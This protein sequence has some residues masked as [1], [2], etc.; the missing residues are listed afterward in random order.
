MSSKLIP[1]I[2]VVAGLIYSPARDKIFIA[3]RPQGVHQGGLWEFPGGKVDRNEAA[4]DALCRELR[5]ELA[6]SVISASPLFRED[7]DYPDKSICLDS[8]VVTD[9]SGIARGNEGQQTAWVAPGSLGAYRFPKANDAIV[10]HILST[11]PGP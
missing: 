7:Y 3:R 1:R 11:S 5:E 6:I 8:W 4:Y 10:A 2:H 9:F